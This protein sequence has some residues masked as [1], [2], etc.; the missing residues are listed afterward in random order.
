MNTCMY[1]FC[2][3]KLYKKVLENEFPT[4]Q[5]LSGECRGLSPGYYVDPKLDCRGYFMCS[6]TSYQPLR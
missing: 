2:Y 3:Y 1:L 5:G 6:I 4:F